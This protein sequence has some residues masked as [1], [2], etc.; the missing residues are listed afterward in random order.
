VDE[1]NRAVLGPRDL[2]FIFECYS[3][4]PG[5]EYFDLQDVVVLVTFKPSGG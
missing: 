1:N 3:T 4:V 5:S 2:I